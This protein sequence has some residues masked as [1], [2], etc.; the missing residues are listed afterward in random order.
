MIYI[1]SEIAVLT[2]ILKVKIDLTIAKTI[3]NTVHVQLLLLAT[4]FP[5]FR[6]TYVNAYMIWPFSL[7]FGIHKSYKICN[8]EFIL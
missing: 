7:E 2:Q 1:K 5:K 4:S 6:I 8:I 3:V